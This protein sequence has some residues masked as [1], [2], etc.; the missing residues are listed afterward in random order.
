M[1]N[2]LKP[3]ALIFLLISIGLITLPHAQHLPVPVFLFFCVLLGWRL[4]AIWRAK[5]LPGPFFLTLFTIIALSI[6]YLNYP[7]FLGRDAGTNLFVTALGL[8]LL[9]LKTERDYYLTSFLTFIV[10]ATQ[11]LFVQSFLMAGYILFVSIVLITNLILINR[12]DQAI[13]PALKT[14]SAM[15]LQALPIALLLFILFPRVQAP[16]WMLFKEPHSAQTGLGDSLEPGS[17]SN[18][19]LSGE[20]VFRVKF[21]GKI[22]PPEQRYWRGPVFSVTDGKK[23]TETPNRFFQRYQDDIEFEGQPYEYTLMMEPQKK[24]W[25]FGLDMPAEFNNPLQRNAL[26]QLINPE[27]PSKRAEFQIISYPDYHTGYITRT[28]Y[29]D[30]LRLPGEPSERILDL[31]D[32]LGGFDSSPQTFIDA[33]MNHFKTQNFYYTLMPPLM[34]DNPIEK[35]LFETRYGFCSH[36]ATAFVYLMRVAD[37]PARIVG[38]YQGGELNPTGNFLEVRQANAHAWAEVWLRDKGWT[39]VDPTTAIAPE[40]VEQDVNIDLQISTGTVNFTP[41]NISVESSEIRSWLKSAKQ[42]WGTVDYQWQRWVIHYHGQNQND[43]LSALGIRN[44]AKAMIWLLAL[45]A[46]TLGLMAFYLLRHS[47]APAAKEVRL[48][49]QF[50]RKLAK[51]GLNRASNETALQFCARIQ[52]HLRVANPEIEQ[53]TALFMHLRYE[54]P[55]TDDKLTLLAQKIRHLKIRPDDFKPSAKDG[56]GE[57]VV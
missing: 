2:R 9:E 30:N 24:N 12:T 4:A 33:V 34:E 18:L 7:G 42:L 40:R 8:K 41:V 10:A 35:F 20:L 22:P 1:P 26:Y 5:L 45:A 29:R 54:K 6:L 14:A 27:D 44:F 47:Q 32:Q 3:H 38:G 11:F 56:D 17:I 55:E 19:G 15:M 49:Q 25:V 37:I 48:Y 39:R 52:S 31:V 21:N 50:C 51:C 28:E 57:R 23:W 13:K 53:I 43:V 16:R 46:L 36:Y